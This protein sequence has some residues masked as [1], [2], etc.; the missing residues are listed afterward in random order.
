MLQKD[1]HSMNIHSM[2]SYD[3]DNTASTNTPNYESHKINK[4]LACLPFALFTAAHPCLTERTRTSRWTV[5]STRCIPCWYDHWHRSVS[6]MWRHKTPSSHT[7]TFG[8]CWIICDVNDIKPFA[9]SS[10]CPER[11]SQLSG[12][13]NCVHNGLQH[14][15]DTLT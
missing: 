2:H 9:E 15:N 8:S 5:M 1:I 14:A 13:L 4:Y 7:R 3:K 12:Y 11:S 10:Y 6:S